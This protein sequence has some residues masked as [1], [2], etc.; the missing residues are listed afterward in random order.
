MARQAEELSAQGE[1]E[2]L[3]LEQL[4]YERVKNQVAENLKQQLMNIL[5]ENQTIADTRTEDAIQKE[6]LEQ[7]VT[8]LEQKAEMAK[9]EVNSASLIDSVRV[10][11]IFDNALSPV[12]L[13]LLIRFIDF[14]H[15]FN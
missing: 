3:R 9:N 1:R 10:K 12:S 5:R 14:V 7:Q 6:A 8:E 13:I 4:E 2:R 11:N 15:F